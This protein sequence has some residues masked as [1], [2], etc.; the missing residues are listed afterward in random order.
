M[1]LQRVDMP[2]DQQLIAEIEAE[3]VTGGGRY[4]YG[5]PRDEGRAARGFSHVDSLIFRRVHISGKP[6]DAEVDHGRII[7]GVVAVVPAAGPAGG[8]MNSS[9]SRLRMALLIRQKIADRILP[10]LGRVERTDIS[11][12]AL[13]LLLVVGDPFRP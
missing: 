13:Q 3:P 2:V 7:A 4:S 11:G 6:P 1:I 12:Y 9:H 5:P 8:D 10:F